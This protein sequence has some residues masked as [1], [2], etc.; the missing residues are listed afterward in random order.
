MSA[1]KS[2]ILQLSAKNATSSN[3][4]VDWT[5][6][7]Q[8]VT[9]K[10][11][12]QV[13]VRMAVIDIG[14]EDGVSDIVLTED[15]VVTLNFGYYLISGPEYMAFMG[16]GVPGNGQLPPSYEIYYLA[17]VLDFFYPA[18]GTFPLVPFPAVYG[19]Q[20]TTHENIRVI[21]IPKGSYSNSSFAEIFTNNMVSVQRDIIN[22]LFPNNSPNWFLP[23]NT[24]QFMSLD[25]WNYPSVNTGSPDMNKSLNWR[26]AIARA[27]YRFIRDGKPPNSIPETKSG[28]AYILQNNGNQPYNGKQWEYSDWVPQGNIEGYAST[29]SYRNIFLGGTQVAL[30][31]D[32]NSNVFK[33]NMFTPP[34]DTTGNWIAK[35]LVAPPFQDDW[36]AF[37]Y[38][39]KQIGSI[40]GNFI[41]QIQDNYNGTVNDSKVNP[42]DLFFSKV[43]KF[44]LDQVIIPVATNSD[45]PKL[46]GPTASKLLVS[47]DIIPY[48]NPTLLST[49]LYYS[50]PAVNQV[51]EVPTTD[52]ETPPTMISAPFSSLKTG[53][54]YLL[55]INGIPQNQLLGED[56]KNVNC[57]L[58]SIITQTYT[59][60]NLITVFNDTS[61]PYIHTGPD[62]TIDSFNVMILDPDTKKPTTLITGDGHNVYLEITNF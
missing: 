54:H 29:H 62:I 36:I 11:G 61:P 31:Y 30:V 8:S 44:N 51:A 45:S 32:S 15:L 4:N 7:T 49:G 50:T 24:E 14:L 26:K 43:L 48:L 6:T 27:Q 40:G 22:D 56:Y 19:T 57:T 33:L 12:D 39:V 41:T 13:N 17:K 25:S 58:S 5:N 46:I 9:I 42:Q 59:D 1:L 55:S 28:D 2:T 38:D 52:I 60:S 18:D 20:F 37:A 10:N 35:L 53:T 34:Q 21:T 16:W 23:Y 3:S 47:Q